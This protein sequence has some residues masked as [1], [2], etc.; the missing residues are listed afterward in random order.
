[1]QS[2]TTRVQGALF[3]FHGMGRKDALKILFFDGTGMVIFYKRF[4]SSVVKLPSGAPPGTQQ[5]EL[6]D[7]ILE[8]R[9]STASRSRTSLRVEAAASGSLIS[10]GMP[11][12]DGDR[13]DASGD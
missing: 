13:S 10:C 12:Y 7:A 6:D 11:A 4:D 9:C 1:M 5:I 2:V 8:A 3:V